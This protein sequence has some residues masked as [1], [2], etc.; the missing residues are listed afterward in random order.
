MS[1]VKEVEQKTQTQFEEEAVKLMEKALEDARNGKHMEPL[2]LVRKLKS[3]FTETLAEE[4]YRLV[5]DKVNV[6]TKRKLYGSPDKSLQLFTVIESRRRPEGYFVSLQL[7]RELPKNTELKQLLSSLNL[8][9]LNAY[10]LCNLKRFCKE[11]SQDVISDCMRTK[12]CVT[13]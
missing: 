8:I 9:A 13:E 5:A 1:A 3:L 12:R 11:V 7:A 6:A 2:K 4:F 10:N